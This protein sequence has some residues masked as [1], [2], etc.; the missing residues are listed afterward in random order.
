MEHY[1]VNAFFNQ[2][3]TAYSYHKVVLDES[4][5]PFDYECLGLNHAYEKLLDL[6]S[7]DVLNKRFYEVFPKGWE[8]EFQWKTI[9]NQAILKGSTSQFDMNHYTIQKWIRVT[10]YPLDQDVFAC[11]YHDVTKEYLLDKEIQGFYP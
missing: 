3:P 6:K 11:E 5:M 4:G 10:V 2:S 1:Y 9:F 7:S 8:G